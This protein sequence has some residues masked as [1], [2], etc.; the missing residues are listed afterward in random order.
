MTLLLAKARG[1]DRDAS[2]GGYWEI[3]T[4]IARHRRVGEEVVDDVDITE[5]ARE[6]AGGAT[7]AGR[8]ANPGTHCSAQRPPRCGGFTSWI[9]AVA[10]EY[11]G[12]T[13]ASEDEGGGEAKPVGVDHVGL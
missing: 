12:A 5:F 9:E 1:P 3:T 4:R 13:D 2:V 7:A 6:Q 10:L 8:N 11:S